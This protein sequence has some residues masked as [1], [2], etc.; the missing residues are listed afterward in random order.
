LRISPPNGECPGQ[1]PYTGSLLP[2]SHGLTRQPA[3]DVLM[4]VLAFIAGFAVGGFPVFNSELAMITLVVFMSLSLGILSQKGLDPR[5]HLRST[6][7]ALLLSFGVSSSTTIL[8]GQLF[9]GQIRID[10]I[11]LAAVLAVALIASEATIAT[12]ISMA[13]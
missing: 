11:M 7:L 13:L 12:T 3:N 5:K 6:A 1:S 8:L 4:M 9:E 2:V 10:R